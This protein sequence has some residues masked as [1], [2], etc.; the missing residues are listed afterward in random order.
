M[1]LV[2]ASHPRVASVGETSALMWRGKSDSATC[3]CGDAIRDCLFWKRVRE[4]MRRR[5]VDADSESFQT[6]FRLPGHRITD[7]I[8]RAEY[9][10]CVLEGVRDAALAVS[11]AWRAKSPA[12]LA[13][14]RALIETAKAPAAETDAGE[15]VESALARL[16]SAYRETVWLCD[17]M[18]LSYGE[19]SS[20]LNCDVNT[21]GSR[22]SRGRRMLRDHF[23][24][25]GHA[26]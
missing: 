14:N 6:D 4:G 8:L 17:G 19:A 18:G 9:R 16:P 2:L 12:T 7:R 10:G 26:M 25:N 23:A 3:S 13:A 15:L 21:I 24:R 5:G 1:T 20:V 22:I 11:P